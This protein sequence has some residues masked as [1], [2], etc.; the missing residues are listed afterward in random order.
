MQKHYGSPSHT[1]GLL[2]WCPSQQIGDH[3]LVSSQNQSRN[4]IMSNP[5]RCMRILLSRATQLYTSDRS[6]RIPPTRP[7]PCLHWFRKYCHQRP[8]K[9]VHD[10]KR[11][12]SRYRNTG[13]YLEGLEQT[14]RSQVGECHVPRRLPPRV[15]IP[16]CCSRCPSRRCRHNSVRAS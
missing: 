16:A 14:R 4:L 2:H 10:D 5:R 8:A 6:P 15:A 3:T 13:A 7:T 12:C 1:V 9:D 11:S